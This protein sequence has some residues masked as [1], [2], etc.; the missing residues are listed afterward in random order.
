MN[1]GGKGGEIK[2]PRG[3]AQGR[4]NYNILLSSCFVLFCS[5]EEGRPLQKQKVKRMNHNTRLWSQVRD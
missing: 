4:V 3:P 5:S 1:A 2:G